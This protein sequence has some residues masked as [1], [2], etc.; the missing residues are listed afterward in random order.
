[1]RPLSVRFSMMAAIASMALLLPAGAAPSARA[2]TYFVP[3]VFASAYD[4]PAYYPTVY[5]P[6]AYIYP[7]VATSWSWPAASVVATDYTVAYDTAAYYVPTQYAPYYT[8]ARYIP[9]YTVYPTVLDSGCVPAPVCCDVVAAPAVR[10]A[11]PPPGATVAPP[12]MPLDRSRAAEPAA[13]GGGRRPIPLDRET[14]EGGTISSRVKSPPE[15]PAAD[16]GQ[17]PAR[18]ENPEK[19]KDSGGSARPGD[20]NEIEAAP[21]L[22]PSPTRRESM[23]PAFPSVPAVLRGRVESDA[24]DFREGVRVTVV[25]LNSLGLAH[26]G[27]SDAFGGFAIRLED[28]DWTVRVTMPSGR[29]YP[30]REVSVRDGKITDRREQREIPN[31]IITY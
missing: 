8:T 31:L 17:S 3:A 4:W 6:S 1:M 29:T 12:A 11:V 24:G 10:V 28:G 22:E 2:A 27:I 15:A 19:K 13:P 16:R 30:I 7:S 21:P 14:P 5:Y 9:T 18:N 20:G 25:S 23:R 26:S